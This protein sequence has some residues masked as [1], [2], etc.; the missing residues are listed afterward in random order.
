[1]SFRPMSTLVAVFAL[2]VA[3][4]TSVAESRLFSRLRPVRN[5]HAYVHSHTPTRSTVRPTVRHWRTPRYQ[6][7]GKKAVVLPER[8]SDYGHWPPYYR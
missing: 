6:A 7:Y 5:S 1:M 3:F 8:L 4:Q 2:T